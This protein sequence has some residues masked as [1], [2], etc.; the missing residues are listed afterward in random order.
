MREGTEAERCYFYTPEERAEWERCA[1]E[2]T[3]EA[4]EESAKPTTQQ[5]MASLGWS[6]AK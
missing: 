2:W 1:V 5:R 3:R 4:R 6:V